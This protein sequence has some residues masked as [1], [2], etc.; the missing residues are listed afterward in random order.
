M[1]GCLVVRPGSGLCNRLRAIGGALSLAREVGNDFVVERFR[2]PLRRWVARCGMRAAFCGL[3]DPKEDA[4]VQERLMTRRD[5]PWVRRVYLNENLNCYDEDRCGLIVD[6]VRQGPTG[7]RWIYTCHDFNSCADYSWVRPCQ[8]LRCRIDIFF[9]D[10]GANGVGLYIQ[11][12]DNRAAIAASP[13]SLFAERMDTEVAEDES[14]RFFLS[15]DEAA[16][17]RE[18]RFRYGGRVLFCEQEA[19]RY[20]IRGEQDAEISLFLLSR[21]RKIEG[22]FCSSFSDVAARIGGLELNV[23]AKRD[24][25]LPSWATNR[26]MV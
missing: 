8:E 2:C 11:R 1:N 19:P 25:N 7:V 23:L 18:L 21:T 24:G 17:K 6:D 5:F 26:T 12:L 22:G 14:V 10:M 13:L 20:T 3:F 16:T 15:T 4:R 9:R